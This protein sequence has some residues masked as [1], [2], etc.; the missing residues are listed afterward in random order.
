MNPTRESL[1]HG[2][3]MDDLDRLARIATLRAF[4]GRNLDLVDRY[5]TA[6]DAIAVALATADEAP[7]G[8]LLV[9]IGAR[10]VD[11]AAQDHQHTW[12]KARTWG[13]A[14]GDIAAYQRYWELARRSAA[15]PEDAVVDRTALRQIWPRLSVTHQQVLYALAVHDGDHAEAAATLGKTLGTFRTHLKDARAAYR[16]LWHEH[17]TPSRMWGK[18]GQRGRRTAAQTI[19]NRR[20]QRARRAAAA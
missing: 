9:V 16:V 12:G 2:F 4:G 6:W 8:G 5:E 20:Q 7:A 13:S 3:S 10:A 15:S 11:R 18:S 19:A 14:E 17:E 1:W